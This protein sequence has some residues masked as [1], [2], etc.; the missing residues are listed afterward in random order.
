MLNRFVL[1]GVLVCA[2]ANLKAGISDL[3]KPVSLIAG[4]T[5]TFEIRN[6]FFAEE[7][8]GFSFKPQSDLEAQF[9]NSTGKITLRASEGF[10]GFTLLGFNFAGSDYEI[11]VFSRALQKAVIRFTPER[12]P[13][14]RLNLMGTFNDWNRNGTKMQDDDGDG[15][16]EAELALD[17][18]QYLYQFVFDD[19]E[20]PDPN[21]PQRVDNGFGSYNSVLSV[22]DPAG[23]DLFLH[24]PQERGGTL[25][26][27]LQ[28]TRE[29]DS[30]ELF[31]LLDNRRLD[32]F[33]PERAFTGKGGAFFWEFT[34]PAEVAKGAGGPTLRAIA[35]HNRHASNLQTLLVKDA[36]GASDSGELR[37]W[38]D[39]I[40][41]AIMI[42]RFSD[43]DSGNTQP[44]ENDSLLPPANYKGGDLQGVLD[45]IE[46]GYFD[47]LGV[48]TLW[49]S[50]VNENTDAA[51]REWPEPHRYFSGYHGYWPTHHQKVERRFGDM[52][53]LRKVVAA[54]HD[55]GMKV[56]LDFIAN[57]VHQG[58]PYFDAHRDWFGTYDLPDGRKN[59]R[60]WDEFRLTTWFEPFLP[61][62]DFVGSAEALD[63]MTDNAIWW[64]KQTGADGFRHDA[65]K[66]IPNRFWQVLTRK[67]RSEIEIPRNQEAF[68]I[69]ETFG[70]YELVGS[71]VNNGQ[72]DSQF[73]FNLYDRAVY[74]FLTPE[75]S[76]ETVAQE[77][78]RTLAV[79]G[80]NH[81]MGNV[82]DSHDKVRFM[83]YADGDVPFNSGEAKEIGWNN[84]PVVDN[85]PSYELAKLYLAYMM[86]I[87]GVPVLYYGD[88]IGLT[89]ADDP[90]NRRMMR[91]D[92][93]LS[94]LE[95]AMLGD[96]RK[97][98]A[99]RRKHPA[100]RYGD[101]RSLVVD[102]DVFVYQRSNVNERILVLL[103]K[104][105]KIQ[106]VSVDLPEF[107]SVQVATDL[108]S[109]ERFEP[110]G[111]TLAVGLPALGWRVVKLD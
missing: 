47:A 11:P 29:L 65:V 50:P 7:Y 16:Y 101:F 33:K 28:A 95:T 83:A 36:A 15:T 84:P 38:R 106:S 26:Y 58:H 108:V 6:F 92:G 90:D 77:L 44:V 61:S 42:D 93:D 72:L 80:T 110:E 10:A 41:Y 105:K 40:I 79:Y 91:F 23:P 99:L 67:I 55:R 111:S 56:L 27:V 49:L 73:N 32:R 100:L 104:G 82:M 9:D 2:A 39:A 18:G 103:N 107:Y 30:P 74:T 66:H 69:G 25:S 62:F 94:K 81:L 109:G 19:R 63:T 78:K 87:P 14:S 76:F 35:V 71:Y 8:D 59:M 3:I 97:I 31:C 43:G 51:F 88:E 21:N 4:R 17:P 102:H 48:N 68:Q 13:Q 37:S 64:L 1:C 60:L 89:G 12:Q 98:V 45:K 20:F 57:H 46:N 22:P 53:L 86:T 96:V 5:S 24:A 75:A 52:P 34:V 85:P 70:S 54:A